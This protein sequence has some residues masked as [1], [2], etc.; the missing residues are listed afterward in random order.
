MASCPGT[1]DL[2][3][4]DFDVNKEDMTLLNDILNTPVTTSNSE[5]SSEWHAAFGATGPPLM[6]GGTATPGDTDSGVADFFMP[7]SLLDMTAGNLLFCALF[8]CL[9]AI[10]LLS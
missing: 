10:S 5:F 3:S 4:A 9:Y 7:S 1:V 8:L 6:A 2:L